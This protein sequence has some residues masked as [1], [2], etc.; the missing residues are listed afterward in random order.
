MGLFNWFKKKKI[1]TPVQD[2]T[3]QLTEETV[4]TEKSVVKEP[5]EDSMDL[6]TMTVAEL[7]ALAKEKGITGYSKLK[8]AD[9]L[10]ALK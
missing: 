3:P 4:I 10:K 2:T 1:D 6:S 8:K 5:K 9:L 7:K